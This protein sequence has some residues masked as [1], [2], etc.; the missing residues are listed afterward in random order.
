MTECRQVVHL[1]SGEPGTAD[2]ISGWLRRHGATVVEL[3]DAFEA[4]VFALTHSATTPDLAFVGADRLGDDEWAIVGYLRQT[5]PGLVTVIYA[6]RPIAPPIAP[7]PRTLLIRPTEALRRMLAE[8]PSALLCRVEQ[9]APTVPP[10]PDDWPATMQ[11]EAPAASASAA[12][13]TTVAQSVG[14]ERPL[15]Q[16]QPPRPGMTDPAY[17]QIILTREEL[18]ALLDEDDER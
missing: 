8:P 9:P 1:R 14:P 5:W 6:D 3:P 15:R 4:C 12:R 18:A 16:A 10:P 11:P 13:P 2:A 17:R 7:G